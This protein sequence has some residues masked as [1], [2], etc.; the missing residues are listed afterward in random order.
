MLIDAEKFLDFLE[1][2][3]QQ[4]QSNVYEYEDFHGNHL[5]HIPSMDPM[6]AFLYGIASG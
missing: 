3:I 2:I 1:N 6:D 4:T 5:A